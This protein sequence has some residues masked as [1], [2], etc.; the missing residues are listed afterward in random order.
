MAQQELQGV[1]AALADAHA[2]QR[3]TA[4]QASLDAMRETEA[5]TQADKLKMEQQRLNDEH[6]Q[7]QQ[8][9]DTTKQLRK[10]QLHQDLEKAQTDIY[11]KGNL[12]PGASFLQGNLQQGGQVQLPDVY[13]DPNTGLPNTLDIEPI[14][15][16]AAAQADIQRVL[17]A[18]K[19]ETTRTEKEAE[20]KEALVKQNDQRQWIMDQAKMHETAENSRAALMRSSQERIA[21]IRATAKPGSGG[22]VADIDPDVFTSHVNNIL[23]GGE[24]LESLKKVYPGAAGSSIITEINN[25]VTR[26]GVPITDAL[27]KKISAIQ[28]MVA[29]I[30]LMDQ[31]INEK[32]NTN[33][34]VTGA[35]EGLGL[36]LGGNSQFNSAAANIDQNAPATAVGLSGVNRLSNVEM[37]RTS[38]PVTVTAFGPKNTDVKNRNSQYSA[39]VKLIEDAVPGATPTQKLLL[40][41]RVGLDKI[42]PTWE[43]QQ[44]IKDSQDK[45]QKVLQ[46]IQ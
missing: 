32:P 5:K 20:A 12:P 21:N 4:Q 36:A 6:D 42:A 30:P 7:H 3:V 23:T 34:K 18:P 8:I 22:G 41:Q 45:I 46:S 35:V 16:H 44:G 25:E 15:K 43:L 13:N 38:H 14:L 28:K 1:L 9:I 37:N 17:N 29:N 11:S 2:R 31:A 26:H 19:A 39:A 40:K 33:N 27:N 24:T 10:L